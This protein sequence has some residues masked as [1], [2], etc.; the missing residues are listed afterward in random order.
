MPDSPLPSDRISIHPTPIAGVMEVEF[1]PLS[2]HRG[3]FRRIYAVESFARTGL[4]PDGPVH[5]NLARTTRA[6]TVRGLHWQKTPGERFGESKL[7]LCIAGRVY[8]VAVDLREGSP[9]RHQHHALELSAE[10]NRGLL[11]PPGVAHGMQ[12]LQD[13][14]ALIYFH[15]APFQ[16]ELE[17]GARVD[18]PILNIRWPLPIENLSERDLTHPLLREETT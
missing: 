16:P 5:V 1:W 8:D 11:I 2:D 13:D 15:S 17:C 3:D 12:A 10:G 18:D 14:S 4:F 9:T 6:G 7:V